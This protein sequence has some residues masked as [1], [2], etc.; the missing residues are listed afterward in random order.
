MWGNLADFSCSKWAILEHWQQNSKGG[1][2]WQVGGDK[3]LEVVTSLLV[4][5]DAD[6]DASPIIWIH[7]KAH[8]GSYIQRKVCIQIV[9][10]LLL[11]KFFFK[12]VKKTMFLNRKVDLY[13][14][15]KRETFWKN[16]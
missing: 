7:S 5:M 9:L 3:K 12:K 15:K 14:V 1:N 10:F 6:K 4:Q 8:L 16:L 11:Q 13:I 2:F